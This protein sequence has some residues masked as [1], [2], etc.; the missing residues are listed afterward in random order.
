[1]SNRT[2]VELN[3]D[4]SPK[5]EQLT[6][7]A[8]AIRTYLRSGDKSFLPQGV[9]FISMRHHSEPSA[10]PT[11]RELALSR[12]S[13]KYQEDGKW[14][15]NYTMENGSVI[16]VVNR[17]SAEM[18]IAQIAGIV[19][20]IAESLTPFSMPEAKCANAK[21]VADAIFSEVYGH[22][23]LVPHSLLCPTFGKGDY[24]HCDCCVCRGCLG[25]CE[26]W[27]ES[28]CANWS[29]VIV[30][31]GAEREK[32]LHRGF[33]NLYEIATGQQA[34]F[35][36]RVGIGMATSAVD[37]LRQRL[38]SAIA[39]L[40]FENEPHILCPEK[41][42][43]KMQYVGK[44]TIPPSTRCALCDLKEAKQQ[45]ATARAEERTRCVEVA[46]TWNEGRRHHPSWKSVG[47]Q[48]ALAI[49][50]DTPISTAQ[51]VSRTY[52]EL[53]ESVRTLIAPHEWDNKNISEQRD[54]AVTQIESIRDKTIREIL[55]WLCSPKGRAG[56][57]E[58]QEYH[59]ESKLESM[60]Q[61]ETK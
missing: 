2:I 21:A 9:T 17:H 52:G 35:D 13:V 22:R 1:M 24:N 46:R 3:H 20:D 57:M 44:V 8:E 34:T 14:R 26:K 53:P 60:L 56:Y 38:E 48:I 37:L 58:S 23:K 30:A 5:T 42:P 54:W 49:E 40:S 36:E 28:L 29:N 12:L 25:H 51:K 31:Y 19:S 47:E 11:A 16:G 39:D 7:W 43:N 18:A 32:P 6:Q 4:Y 33:V 27:K 55:D 15:I 10:I 45:L 41:H 50:A 59:V 61:K